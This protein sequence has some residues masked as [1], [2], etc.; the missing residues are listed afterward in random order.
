MAKMTTN[1]S[2]QDRVILFC[3]ATGIPYAEVGILKRAMRSMAIRGFIE[4][5]GPTQ[6]YVLT[7]SGRA[8]LSG[9]L[10]N[11][12]LPQKA[13]PRAALGEAAGAI[14]GRSGQ[15]DSG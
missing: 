12:R 11:A 3:V 14:S 1:L 13:M 5:Q 10:E 8:T 7:A 4:Q 6:T 15:R 2:A 9:V